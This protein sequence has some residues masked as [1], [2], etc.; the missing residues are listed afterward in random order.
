MRENTNV[1]FGKRRLSVVIAVAVLEQDIERVLA[2][3]LLQVLESAFRRIS[4]ILDHDVNEPL[5]VIRQPVQN[6][7]D[8][9]CG[10]KRTV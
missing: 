10:K 9:G 5:H 1:E 3:S 8:A 7:A 2:V 6:P 4:L